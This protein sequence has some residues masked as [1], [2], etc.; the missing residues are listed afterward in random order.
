MGQTC[1]LMDIDGF[2][3]D[4]DGSRQDPDGLRLDFGGLRLDLRLILEY[5]ERILDNFDVGDSDGFVKG[6][7]F[8]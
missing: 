8:P 4:F 3:L 1:I 2:R 6:I 7:D 5:L